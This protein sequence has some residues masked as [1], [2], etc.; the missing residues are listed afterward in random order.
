MHPIHLLHS[1]ICGVHAKRLIW[2]RCDVGRHVQKNMS[3]IPK[4]SQLD[5]QR[6]MEKNMAKPSI[7]SRTPNAEILEHQASKM[8]TLPLTHSLSLPLPICA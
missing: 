2:K 3:Y 7:A 5:Y 6:D 4:K 1:I 8:H